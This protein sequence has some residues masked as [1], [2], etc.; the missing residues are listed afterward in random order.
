MVINNHQ[1]I[2]ICTYGTIKVWHFC[3]K[4]IKDQS[5]EIRF[6]GKQLQKR[7]LFIGLVFCTY[8]V[9]A[10][11]LLSVLSNALETRNLLLNFPR[12]PVEMEGVYFDV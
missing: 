10:L 12:R 8:V 3:T 6:T 9:N 1:F 4:I 2:F 7:S 11:K 5:F